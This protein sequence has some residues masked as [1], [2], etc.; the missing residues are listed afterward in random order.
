MTPMPFGPNPIPAVL[1]R[2]HVLYKTHA[3]P[4]LLLATV[5][6]ASPREG[7]HEIAQDILHFYQSI[8]HVLFQ[9]SNPV[10]EELTLNAG[11]SACRELTAMAQL[12]TGSDRDLYT[13]QRH[14][15]K[16]YAL[17]Q[18]LFYIPAKGSV[19]TSELERRESCWIRIRHD[20]AK[21]VREYSADQR[22][23]DFAQAPTQREEQRYSISFQKPGYK[24]VWEDAA[25][26]RLRKTI[27]ETSREERNRFLDYLVETGG[28]RRVGWRTTFSGPQS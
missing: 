13:Y 10:L 26:G 6:N 5:R 14:P 11:S 25:K 17:R 4:G 20:E 22:G 8:S 15:V 19:A 7:L 3:H 16:T 28:G 1:Q 9:D 12:K 27:A 23:N 24:R 18:D 2:G 21:P